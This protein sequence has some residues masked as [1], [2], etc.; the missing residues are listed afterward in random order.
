MRRKKTIILLVA[1]FFLGV[2]LTTPLSNIARLGANYDTQ[3]SFEDVLTVRELNSFLHV[4]SEFMQKDLGKTM[5]QV[6]LQENSEIPYQVKR[7]LSN[8]GWNAE[9]FFS[10]E[11][12]L[13]ELVS[14]ATLQ[15]NLED[16]KKLLKEMSGAGSDN[17]KDIVSAQ[18]KHFK[19]L[20]YNPKELAIV[21]NNLYQIEQVLSGKGVLK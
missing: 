1:L 16:N 5:G 11:Q 7:W 14:I 4:W 10:L 21:R 2:I 19:A 9:R 17:I 15:N 12:R 18:E 8:K 13:K 20:S 3:P 6:S